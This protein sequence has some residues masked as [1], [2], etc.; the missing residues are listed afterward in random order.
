MPQF[1]ALHWTVKPG[2]EKQVEELF[3]RSGRAASFDITDDEGNEVG[4]LIAT[5]VFMKG[6]T[7]VRV[8]EFE[9]ELASLIRHMP[10]QPAVQQLEEWLAPHIEVPRDLGTEGGFRDFFQLSAMRPVIV[11]HRDDPY[12]TGAVPAGAPAGAVGAN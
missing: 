6:N 10:K 7:I 11:R 3:Q 2:H 1:A 12:G 8:I 4:R 9:G 5:A